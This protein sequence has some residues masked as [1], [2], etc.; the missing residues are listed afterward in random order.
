MG[1]CQPVNFCK[2]P[3]AAMRSAPLHRTGRADRHESRRPHHAM[4]GRQFACAR[5]AVGR[6]EIK[7]VGKAHG[8]LLR[9][10][11]VLFNRHDAHS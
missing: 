11:A 9:D 6:D 5:R 8:G 3:S 4:G 10:N 2:P 7:V 1:P